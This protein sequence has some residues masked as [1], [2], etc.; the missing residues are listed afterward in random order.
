MLQGRF[1]G[2]LLTQVNSSLQIRCLFK[3]FLNFEFY[4]SNFNYL[5]FVKDIKDIQER[6]KIESVQEECFNTL[7]N[8]NKLNYPNTARFGRL[9]VLYTDLRKYAA[10]L[11]EETFFRSMIAKN[12]VSNLLMEKSL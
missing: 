7:F 11:T 8:Y 4:F 1:D 10:K 2:I 5:I 6:G 9:L 12:D 3:S